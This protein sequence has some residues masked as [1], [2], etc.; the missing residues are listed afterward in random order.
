MD[1]CIQDHRNREGDD[2]FDIWFDGK[3]TSIT[4]FLEF[5]SCDA[6]EKGEDIILL[7]R[8]KCLHEWELCER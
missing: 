5:P 8:E 7:Y 2:R 1:E 6:F 4:V 3:V